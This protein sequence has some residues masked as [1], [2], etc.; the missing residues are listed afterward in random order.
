MKRSKL[1]DR[2]FDFDMEEKAFEVFAQ[3]LTQLPS[4]NGLYVL[5]QLI[6]RLSTSC[7][8]LENALKI[9]L[10]GIFDD[11]PDQVMW[12]IL[13]IK[14]RSQSSQHDPSVDVARTRKLAET[15][16]KIFGGLS[17][18]STE[19][20]RSYLE[21]AN[22]LKGFMGLNISNEREININTRYPQLNKFLKK[23]SVK[24]RGF[25]VPLKAFIVPALDHSRQ[26][27]EDAMYETATASQMKEKKNIKKVISSV[28]IVNVEATC[29]VMNSMQ[30]PVKFTLVA[31]NGRKYSF[32]AKIGDDLALDARVSELMQTF[33]YLLRSTNNKHGPK[34]LSVRSFFV[35][36]LGVREGLI[37]WIDDLASFK[38]CINPLIAREGKESALKIFQHVERRGVDPKHVEKM[39]KA[40]YARNRHNYIFLEYFVGQLKYNF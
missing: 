9:I 27:K 5:S 31:S 36:P 11:F 16:D 15:V 34:R 2:Q 19:K 8:E 32:L 17:A 18:K 35:I 25:L 3:V 13:D 23:E 37:E 21:L 22:Q 28:T 20:Y 26:R 24:G 30:K 29:K 38:S 10:A 7:P 33:D 12:N 6:G 4:E 40:L 1:G 39:C 14:L